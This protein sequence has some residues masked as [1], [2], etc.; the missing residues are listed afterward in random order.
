[1]LK[2]TCQKEVELEAAR[3]RDEDK[4]F[5]L[6]LQAE[7]D[8][9]AL[10]GKHPAL[11]ILRTWRQRLIELAQ[12]EVGE[13]QRKEAVRVTDEAF[14]QMDSVP[15][16]LIVLFLRQA[17]LL[18]VLLVLQADRSEELLKVSRKIH[19]ASG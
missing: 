7:R 2:L 17:K 16:E 1:M 10:Y 3:K 18:R 14:S 6:Q 19:N 13:L 11:G 4:A 9:E 12:G 8:L 15:L 5:A